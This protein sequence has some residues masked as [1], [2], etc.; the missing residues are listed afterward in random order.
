MVLCAGTQRACAQAET[1]ITLTV[2]SGGS[3]VTTVSS[4][5]VVTLTATVM[6]GGKPVTPGQVNFCDAAAIYCTDIHLLGMAQLTKTGVAT[7]KFRP[8]IG[9]H[10]YKAVFVGTLEDAPSTS[11]PKALTVAGR[12][13]TT[14]YYSG[15][16]GSAGDYTLTAAVVSTG[17]AAPTGNVSILDVGNGNKV[18]GTAKLGSAT[19]NPLQVSYSRVS[20]AQKG[21]IWYNVVAGDFNGDG[22]PD[23][24]ATE[25]QGCTPVGT[26][27]G[28]VMT[29][30]LGKGDE[31]FNATPAS[32]KLFDPF[33]PVTGDFNQDG[34][35]DF[36]VAYAE[37]DNPG[38]ITIF[39]G[40][41][42][43]TFT[44][45]A[46]S[47]VI[48]N[49]SAIAVGD[50]NGDGIPDLA[51]NDYSD[52]QV[53][54]LL[55]DGDGTF[56]APAPFPSGVGP[57]WIAAGDFNDDGNLDLVVLGQ[58][59]IVRVLLGDG[60]GAFGPATPT[61][62]AGLSPSGLVVGDFNGDGNLDLA[63]PA[64][65]CDPPPAGCSIVEA[66][67]LAVGLGNGDGTF[68]R[69]ENVANGYYIDFP[70]PIVM[71]DFYGYSILDLAVADPHYT[72]T[73]FE[74][75]GGTYPYFDAESISTV[76]V[77]YPSSIAAGDF[78]GDGR[79]DLALTGGT[80][81]A[82]SII[83]TE[84]GS[85]AYASVKAVA[86]S[87]RLGVQQ[88][89]AQY[90]GDDANQPS[91]ST[92]ISISAP[93]PKL[94]LTA[95][96]TS[97]IRGSPVTFTATI[98]GAVGTPT[99][100]VTFL[101]GKTHLGSATLNTNGVAAITTKALAFGSNSM[102]ASYKGNSIYTA[103]VSPPV[104]ISVAGGLTPAIKLA[105]SSNSVI[106]RTTVTFKATLSGSNTT[107]TGTVSFFDGAR[108]MITAT[109][110]SDG[111]ASITT[112]GLL[113]GP[114]SITAS[115]SGD[116]YYLA[117]TSTAF[118]LTVNPASPVASLTSSATS[119]VDGHPVTFT[120]TVN[121]AGVT[122]TGNMRF[123]D[124]K[125]QLYE[126]SLNANGAATF[127]TSKLAVGKHSMTAVYVGNSN[128]LPGTSSAV[129]VTVTA[130]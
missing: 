24:L 45:A 78:N 87:P 94:T 90:S 60:N 130:P 31:T 53:E 76:P 96:T 106:Y 109:I 20:P 123:L 4:G 1:T 92:P 125:T 113:G 15:E 27:T 74:G 102:T 36:A 56:K 108:K 62:S 112:R 100:A 57:G 38:A 110:G 111:V 80:S 16:V 114:H 93:V 50:F 42:D 35:L 116:T 37:E 82:I 25:A 59:G 2:T 68:Q 58:D 101:D 43:G 6:A 75:L 81:G 9:S 121:G 41:G 105:G 115:Y 12:L 22:I 48:T 26:C 65:Q 23:L 28:R 95:S 73:I 119:I 7:L 77:K 63:V 10:N 18:I 39:L 83:Q 72:V 122:P 5:S 3:A 55:G 49:P 46:G 47:P 8:G 52:K 79:T 107:P 66:G 117:A 34:I 91:T 44:A 124:G 128:Y 88:V 69:W 33:Y 84:T 85:T 64:T 21:D 40:N 14:T 127:T 98:T 99:G 54:I 17:P 19:P 32:L 11:G 118:K 70:G 89:V 120:A 71:G 86:I 61:A 51:V 97:I 30:L 13:S 67:I 103:A 129:T 126:A 29:V 104:V